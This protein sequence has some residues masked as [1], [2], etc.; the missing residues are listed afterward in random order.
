MSA[1]GYNVDPAELSAHSKRVADIADRVNRVRDAVNEVGLG[2][3]EVY[4]LLCSPLMIPALQLFQGDNDELVSS[5]AELG[6][7]LA[8]TLEARATDYRNL[9]DMT[10]DHMGK[11]GEAL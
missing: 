3:V 1:P 10:S 9:E 8:E 11:L 4:G 7:A 2:G 5:A 6:T